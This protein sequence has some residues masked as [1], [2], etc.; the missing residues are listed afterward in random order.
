M[1]TRPGNSTSQRSTGASRTRSKSRSAIH[2]KGS[3]K[4]I[5][6]A[7]P[8]KAARELLTV[9]GKHGEKMGK[10]GANEDGSSETLGIL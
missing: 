7:A 3:I 1:F 8:R 5:T 4:G 2:C 9:D 6:L 10:N